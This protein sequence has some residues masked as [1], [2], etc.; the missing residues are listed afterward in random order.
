MDYESVNSG[1]KI[2][3]LGLFEDIAFFSSRN[4]TRIKSKLIVAWRFKSVNML[5]HN[6]RPSTAGI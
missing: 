5:F 1:T 2:R 6:N 3:L 4:W